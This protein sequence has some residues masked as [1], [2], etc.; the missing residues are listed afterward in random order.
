LPSLHD[1][2]WGLG[3]FEQTP[4]AGLQTPTSWQMS[5]AWHTTGVPPIHAPLP[6]QVSAPLQALPSPHEVPT[7]AG[8]FEQAPV[9]WSHVPATWQASDA[10]QVTGVPARH[11]PLPLQVSLPL[12]ALPSPHDVPAGA[13]GF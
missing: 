10:V 7:G 13:G 1:V 12:Q 6:L 5:S 11:A 3:G 9:A 2:P 8:G 4:L